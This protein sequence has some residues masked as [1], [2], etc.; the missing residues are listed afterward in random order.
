[1]YICVLFSLFGCS[2]VFRLFVLVVFG[3]LFCW[4]RGLFTHN[5]DIV[6]FRCGGG[7]TLPVKYFWCFWGDFVLFGSTLIPFT[8]PISLCMSVSAREIFVPGVSS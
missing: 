3:F 6:R 2:F 5:E 8:L 1:M 7:V 4:C